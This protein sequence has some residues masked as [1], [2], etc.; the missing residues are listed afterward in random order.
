[1]AVVIKI[2]EETYKDIIKNGFIYDEDNEVVT[3]VIENGTPLPK[4]YGDLIDGDK[5][6]KI[7][8]V[9]SIPAVS[10]TPTIIEADKAENEE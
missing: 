6:M 8:G 9:K 7:N 5:I 10:G 1:M 2:S 3:H 4:G